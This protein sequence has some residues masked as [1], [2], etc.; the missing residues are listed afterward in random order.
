MDDERRQLQS[1]FKRFT[2]L[3][4]IVMRDSPGDR[5]LLDVEL[6]PKQ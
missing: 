6:L 5:S 3:L 4:A 2:A 1:E